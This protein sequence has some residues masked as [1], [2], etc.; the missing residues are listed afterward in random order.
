MQPDLDRIRAIIAA[1]HAYYGDVRPIFEDDRW[2]TYSS[3][4]IA[5]QLA[6]D[7]RVLDV[8]CGNGGM[9]FDLCEHFAYGLGVDTDP[10]HL[11]LAEA[12]RSERGMRNVEFML[13]DYPPEAVR[14][15]EASFDLVI[16][17]RGPLPDSPEGIA[18]AMRL[19]RPEGLLLCDEIAEQHHRTP[20]VPRA[21][22]VRDALAAHGLDV[23]LVQDMFTKSRFADVYAWFGYQ[24]NIWSW[25]GQPL[26]APD[27]PRIAEFVL[28]FAAPNGE[29][30][31]T[32]HVA[33]VA[34]VKRST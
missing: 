25:L 14:L 20:T 34:G 6:P 12:A 8:G 18:A 13:L 22:Q 3:D 19:L 23:R 15:P 16:S 17:N 1:P 30:E 29:I 10:E 2:H 31:V 9:L 7:A 27:D 26:P 5:A 32:S 28:R 33:R 24:C 4:L 21:T 11:A